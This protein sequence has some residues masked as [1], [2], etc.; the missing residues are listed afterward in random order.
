MKK[1]DVEIGKVY[2]VKVSGKL[3]PVKII[4]PS[5]YGG[6]VGENLRTKKRVRIKTAA[7]LRKPMQYVYS[8]NSF[9]VK[10]TYNG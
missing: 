5:I 6:W 4:M 7:R 3:S 1:K 9:E 8:C 10:E 2:Q